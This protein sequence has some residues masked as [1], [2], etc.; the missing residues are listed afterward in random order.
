MLIQY[1]I[2]QPCKGKMQ[3]GGHA[4][5]LWEQP[6]SEA[7]RPRKLLSRQNHL[8]DHV[9]DRSRVPKKVNKV[10][11][12]FAVC[13][14]REGQ[15]SMI[16]SQSF[17]QNRVFSAFRLSEIGENI[18]LLRSKILHGHTVTVTVTG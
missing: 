10:V 11:R 18:R 1:I 2:V 3:L 5:A 7:M 17:I 12:E 15:K 8:F 14:S 6:A 16:S 9:F 13:V 4:R